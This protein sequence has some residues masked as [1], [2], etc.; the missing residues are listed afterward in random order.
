MRKSKPGNKMKSFSDNA[1]IDIFIKTQIF[2]M[3]IYFVSF[4]LF[5]V[6]GLMADLSVKYDLLYSLLSFGLASFAVGFFIGRKL[7]QNGMLAGVIYSLPLN[8][9]VVLLSLIFSDFTVDLNIAIT[10][11]VLL[12][13][14]GVGGIVAVNSRLKR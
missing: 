5:S 2:A 1:T 7:R 13:T 10:A 3:I 9:L 14:A 11:I 6:I 4:L 12:V 8:T